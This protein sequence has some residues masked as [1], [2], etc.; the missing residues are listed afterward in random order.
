MPDTLPKGRECDV[1]Q[2]GRPPRAV[3]ISGE[4]EAE[5]AKERHDRFDEENKI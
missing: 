4:S 3:L 1:L 2:R 5:S